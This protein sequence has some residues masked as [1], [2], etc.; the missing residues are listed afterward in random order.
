MRDYI[1]LNGLKFR[2]AAENWE[3]NEERPMVIRRLMSGGS[4]VT[5]GPSTF[6]GWRGT[7]LVD[8]TPAPDFGSIDH[9]RITYR[10]R[11]ALEFL[12]HYGNEYQVVIDRGVGEK[13]ISPMWTAVDN[14]FRINLSLVKL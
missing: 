1:I 2:T 13:S 5:F 10:L 3:P 7:V 9:M 4:N 6:T 14:V 12:D 11:Q 8:V